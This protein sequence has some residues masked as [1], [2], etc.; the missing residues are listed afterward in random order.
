VLPLAFSLLPAP[1]PDVDA[2]IANIEQANQQAHA[3]YTQLEKQRQQGEIT[4]EACA[5]AVNDQLLPIIERALADIQA[6]ST[7]PRINPAALTSLQRYFT[8]RKDSLLKLERG[9]RNGDLAAM[10]QHYAYW[11]KADLDQ[12]RLFPLQD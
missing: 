12:Q 1:P 10:Q 2:T 11:L 4:T 6:L 7:S 9:L 3:L 5:Q 8:L